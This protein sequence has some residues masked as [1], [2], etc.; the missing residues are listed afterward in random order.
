[1]CRSACLGGTGAASGPATT[2]EGR[3][4][5]AEQVERERRPASGREVGQHLAD[6]RCELKAVPR[7]GRGDDDLRRVRQRVDDEMLVGGVGEVASR[8]DGVVGAARARV[9]EV[10]L[11]ATDRLVVRRDRP[12]LLLQQILEVESGLALV[13]LR[14]AAGLLGLRL[15]AVSWRGGGEREDT[16]NVTFS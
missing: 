14:A 6:D 7:A 8:P 10:A 4:R 16:G 9:D 1:M 15:L 13:R 2:S 11:L 5:Q 12:D 3:P